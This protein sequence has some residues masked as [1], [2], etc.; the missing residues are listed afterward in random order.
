MKPEVI[1]H[2]AISLDGKIEGFTVDMGTFY[3]IAG[4]FGCDTHL[5]GS[6]TI[7]KA[8]SQLPELEEGEIITPVAG[9]SRPLLV[10]PDSRGRIRSWQKLRK[11]GFWRDVLVLCSERTPESYLNFLKEGKVP[12]LVFGKDKV[13]LRKAM[14]ALAADFGTKKVHLDGGGILNGVMLREG[15]VDE[16]SVLVHPLFMGSRPHR[17]VFHL[18][19]G[20]GLKEPLELELK[21]V[22]KIEGDGIWLRYLVK[23]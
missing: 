18:Q 5:A 7:H 2:N 17:S 15:L 22:E 11:A 20:A 6:V 8:E 19:E 9:D 12:Y 23:N 16:V 3:Q 13:D 1:L 14:E 4:N 10:V 21:H